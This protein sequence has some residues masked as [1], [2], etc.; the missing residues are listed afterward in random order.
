[1]T[2]VY[3]VRHGQTAWNK[4]EVFRGRADVPLD[5]EGLGEAELAAG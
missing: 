4:G 5:D 2:S 1:M 3:L